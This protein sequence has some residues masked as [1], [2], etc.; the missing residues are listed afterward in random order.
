MHPNKGET[1]VKAKDGEK[2]S[3]V[4]SS[5]GGG[6]IA[7]NKIDGMEVELS[8]EY[9]TI[10]VKQQDTPGMVAHIT[11]CLSNYDVNIAFM[12]LYREEKGTIAYTII[13]ADEKIDAH[14]VA[15]IKGQPGILEV[16]L[17]EGI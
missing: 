17:I 15:L 4:A 1:T 16:K 13:E 14:V 8:G 2:M 11:K 3:V 10:L 7:V 12:R 5:I 9:F 6:S